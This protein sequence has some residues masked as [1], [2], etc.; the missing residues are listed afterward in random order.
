M[1]DA[2]LCRSYVIIRPVFVACVEVYACVSSLLGYRHFRHRTVSWLQNKNH[3]LVVVFG[4]YE[5][6]A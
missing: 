5:D 2:Q 6:T 3:R 4:N 1:S